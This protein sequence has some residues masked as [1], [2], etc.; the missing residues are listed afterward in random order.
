MPVTLYKLSG[1]VKM[2]ELGWK[3]QQGPKP[4]LLLFYFLIDSEEKSVTMFA[5]VVSVIKPFFLSQ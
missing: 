4:C 2:I 1:I 3:Y 5:L